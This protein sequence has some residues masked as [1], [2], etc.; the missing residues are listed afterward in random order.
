VRALLRR[1]ADDPRLGALAVLLIAA[2]IYLPRLGADPLAG[3]EGH[4]ALPGWEL[5]DRL[6]AGEPLDRAILIPRLFQR[7]YL[8]KRSRPGANT[9]SSTSS[10]T[11]LWSTAA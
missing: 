1:C 11:F 4:R 8:R 6:E 10:P 9:R 5:L 7:P 2:L 3:T